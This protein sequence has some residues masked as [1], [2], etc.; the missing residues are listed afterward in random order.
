MQNA[1]NTISAMLNNASVTFASISY[2]TT[3]ATAAAH[4]HNVVQKHVV[5][6]VQLFAN[7]K[8]A[9]AV[10]AN[11][12]KKSAASIASNSAANVAAF[13]QQSN[14]F[15]HTACYS[16]VQ[17]KQNSNLYLYA[18]FNNVSSAVYT[19]NNVVA[20]KQQVAALLTAS[21]AA[22]LLQNDNTVT[23]VTHNIQHNVQ[24]RTIA[25]ANIKS[26]TANKQ[27]VTFK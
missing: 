4:K 8:Q 3:V 1:A 21:A 25:L 13:E 9:T 26:V 22:K 16:I 27:T 2:T 18:I 20:S 5:A 7:I 10:F 11:A 12:V 19:I 15:T 14:Y 17:H 24:V 6:N 23:N